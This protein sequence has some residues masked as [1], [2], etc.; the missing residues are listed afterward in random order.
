MRKKKKFA[1]RMR[2]EEDN[3]DRWVIS[4]A[5]FITL[6]FAFFVTLYATSSVNEGRYNVVADSLGLAFLDVPQLSYPVRSSKVAIQ[7]PINSTEP[8]GKTGFGALTP[9]FLTR[10]TYFE[11]TPDIRDELGQMASNGLMEIEETKQWLEIS[12]NTKVLFASGSAKL[13]PEAAAILKPLATIFQKLTAPIQVEGFTDSVPIEN[14]IFPSNWELSSARAAAVVRQFVAL[15]LPA[16]QFVVVGY[17]KNFPIASNKTQVGREIN[18]RVVMVIAKSQRVQRLVNNTFVEK[19]RPLTQ[20][21]KRKKLIDNQPRSLEKFRTPDGRV[22][23][24]TLPERKSKK[25]RVET[26]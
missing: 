13:L 6:L 11:M 24:T 12:L 26:E 4:Y 21:E 17:G 2:H 15:E 22:R 23:Y 8:N 5:D 3:A 9:H 20:A 14:E 18:R 7:E 1:N 10:P 19:E 25:N 16:S